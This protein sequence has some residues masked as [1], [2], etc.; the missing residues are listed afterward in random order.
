MGACPMLV[1]LVGKP[2]VGKSTV[3]SAATLA[4]AE[5]ANYP[6][7]TIA[8]NRGVGYARL[9]PCPHTVLGKACTPRT[10]YCADGT[11]MIP[12]ELLDVAGLVPGAHEGKGLG[13]KFLDELSR[14]DALVHVVDASGGTSIDGNPVP[15]GSHDPI[16]DVGFLAV[17]DGT[18]W[19]AI[20]YD[21]PQTLRPKLGLADE[22]GLAGAGLWAL[23][24]ERGV[25]AYTQL[26]AEFR[27]GRLPQDAPTS[28]P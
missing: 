6:F 4:T 26:L 16:E 10:G 21:P 20:Y 23:G 5:I 13:N 1:G 17:R 15:V 8:P 24:Y 2:N 28:N 12:V 14:A 7:T 9:A 3:F 25:P 18:G 11:R 19:T 27:A 22:R